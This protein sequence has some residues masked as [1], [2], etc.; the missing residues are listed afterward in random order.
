[1]AKKHRAGAKTKI[2]KCNRSERGRMA[3]ATWYKTQHK[4]RILFAKQVRIGKKLTASSSPTIG[5]FFGEATKVKMC[6]RWFI[7]GDSYDNCAQKAS[8]VSK[9]DP[10]ADRKA[11]Y[12]AFMTKCREV[13]KKSN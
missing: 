8:H 13:G 11:S 5:L 7:K 1:M 10:P 2:P 4:M 6:A 9:E 12:L 3:M